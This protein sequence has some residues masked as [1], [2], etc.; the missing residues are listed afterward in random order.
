[1]LVEKYMIG[2]TTIEIHDD[3]YKNKTKEDVD[4]IIRRIEEIGRKTL[5]RENNQ[6]KAE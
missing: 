5:Y 1:M 3:A 6:A 4:K 2:N